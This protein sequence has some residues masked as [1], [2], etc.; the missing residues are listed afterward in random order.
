MVERSFPSFK[1]DEVFKGV[2]GILKK[3]GI[4][5]FDGE[6][7]FAGKLANSLRIQRH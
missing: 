5:D 3:N 7:G 2:S 4:E 6:T 1:G